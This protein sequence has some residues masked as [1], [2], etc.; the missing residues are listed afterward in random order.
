M[1]SV[2]HLVSPEHNNHLIAA[3]V[4]DVMSPTRHGFYHLWLFT[5]RNQFMALAGLYV[6]E[7]ETCQTL[8]NKKFLCLAVVVVLMVVA[9]PVAGGTGSHGGC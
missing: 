3:N 5:H 4:G 6:T 2:K 9:R 1:G 8:D 7:F